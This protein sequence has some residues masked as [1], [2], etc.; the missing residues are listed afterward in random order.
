MKSKCVV[1]FTSKSHYS[2]NN[3]DLNDNQKRIFIFV[4]EVNAI[5]NST[6]RQI[7]GSDTI[8]ANADLRKLRE[9]D[10]LNQKGKSKFTDYTSSE[11][12]KSYISNEEEILS[13][14]PPD[15]SAPLPDLSALPSDDDIPREL[16]KLIESLDKRTNDKE[17]IAD[18]ILQL[19]S[20]K[21]MKGKVIAH[22]L[23]KSEKY[24]L[25]NF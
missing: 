12:L 20:H 23:G 5:D 7:N 17:K 18:V 24:I 8:T 21:P 11:L 14:L 13:A 6:A 1:F 3:F 4:R 9:L 10:L 25:G 15:L 2:T 19:C 22:V 16:K